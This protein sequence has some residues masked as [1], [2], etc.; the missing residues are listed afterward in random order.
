MSDVADRV[1]CVLFEDEHLLVVNKPPGWNTHAPAPHAGE[2]IY[3]WLRHRELRWAGLAIIQRLDKETS[4]VLLFGKTPLANRAL[5]RQFAE[6]AVRKRYQ[7]VT[8]RPPPDLPAVQR[9]FISRA[10]DRYV[11]RPNGAESD[12]AETSFEARGRIDAGW[13]VEAQ[14]ATGRTHQIRVHAAAAGF[15]ILGDPLYGGSPAA[16][17]HL[18]AAALVIDHPATGDRLTFTAPV[19]WSAPPGE[20]LRAAMIAPEVTDAFRW[21]HGA[22]DGA[23]RC[24]VDR[25]GPCLLA[26]TET[27]PA[28]ADLARLGDWKER[29]GARAVYVKRRDRFVRQSNP[30]DAAPRLLQGEPAPTEFEIRENGVRYLVSFAEGYSTGLFLDQRDNRRRLLTGHVAAGFP[31]RG[32]PGAGGFEVLNLFAYTCGFSVCAARSGALVTSVDLSRRY[33]EWGR[34]NFAL[35]GLDPAAHAFLYGEAFDWLRRFARKDRRFDAVLVDPPTFAT[36]KT[37]GTFRAEAD[38]TRL[39]AAAIAVLKPGGV[40]FASTNAAKLEPERFVGQ[41]LDAARSAGRRAVQQHYVPQPPDFPISRDE[42]GYL[43]TLWLRLA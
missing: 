32:Q 20:T 8:D 12:A 18:H 3:D 22:A 9:S 11:A 40:L 43:K 38:W 24:Y 16:R 1:P 35:N 23:G 21:V 2:G 26:Q 33:L 13:L 15:P 39:A 14:P 42:P 25:Y 7:L 41:V 27:D 30:A 6:R 29:T 5:T 37:G 28:P 34:R 17:L 10:G 19:D 31:L 4:G 36:S